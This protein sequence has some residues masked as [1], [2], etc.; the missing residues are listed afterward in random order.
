MKDQVSGQVRH[1]LTLGA[2]V[3]YGKGYISE[4]DAVAIV[5]VLMAVIPMVHSWWTKRKAS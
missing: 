2:G 1:L 5:G 4:V 3:L